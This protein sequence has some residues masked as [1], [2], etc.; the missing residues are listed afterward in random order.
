[1]FNKGIGDDQNKKKKNNFFCHFQTFKM[2]K[3]Q[4]K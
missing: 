4:I 2:C 1:M 3:M